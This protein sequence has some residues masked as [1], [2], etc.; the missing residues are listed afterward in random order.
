M[1]SSAQSM[2]NSTPVHTMNTPVHTINT[3]ASLDPLVNIAFYPAWLIIKLSTII[4]SMKVLYTIIIYTHV[5]LS[6]IFVFFF[7]RKLLLRFL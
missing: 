5:C 1:T 2:S 4:K 3:L 6:L 7:V